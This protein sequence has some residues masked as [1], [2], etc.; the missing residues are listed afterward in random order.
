[1]RLG[2]GYAADPAT[3]SGL[4]GDTAGLRRSG[5]V[6]VGHQLCIRFLLVN[7]AT[8]MGG[9]VCLGQTMPLHA[10]FDTPIAAAAIT[11]TSR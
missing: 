1:M 10:A 2:Y 8:P 4:R 6:V 7:I 5:T 9:N 11:I 3:E